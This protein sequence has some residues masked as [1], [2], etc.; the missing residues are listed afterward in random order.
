MHTLTACSFRVFPSVGVYFT[1]G[2]TPVRR[3]CLRG[4]TNL[5]LILSPGFDLTC[6]F[7]WPTA[8]SPQPAAGFP[9][10][11]ETRKTRLLTSVT[12]DWPVY[13][14]RC[15]LATWLCRSSSVWMRT[16][17]T[18]GPTSPNRSFSTA[19][20]SGSRWKPCCGMAA[21]RFWNTWSLAACGGSSRTPS[22]RLSALWRSLMNQ[23]RSSSRR[24]PRK[25]TLRC[26]CTTG[27]TCRTPPSRRW[28]WAGQRA[29]PT[30]G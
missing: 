29:Q 20:T 24:S 12:R 4:F 28:T 18:R 22:R 17:S 23:T 15:R 30:A 6:S 14:L 8:R 9:V 26:R 1:A 19:R 10:P 13:L 27:P 21:R 16:T 2:N 25:A 3:C 11:E 5:R 7:Q